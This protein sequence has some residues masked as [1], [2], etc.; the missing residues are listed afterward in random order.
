MQ[1][2]S[3]LFCEVVVLGKMVK[4]KNKHH[5]KTSLETVEAQ[6]KPAEQLNL[7]NS[8][9][10]FFSY[11]DRQSSSIMEDEKKEDNLGFAFASLVV[12]PIP[13]EVFCD[14]FFLFFIILPDT[15]IQLHKKREV[16][17]VLEPP[18]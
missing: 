9:H 13:K 3:P 10:L 7:L 6:S 5:S 18:H 12:V 4:N 15:I 8:K 16:L 2:P 14:C 11:I 1:I 17:F